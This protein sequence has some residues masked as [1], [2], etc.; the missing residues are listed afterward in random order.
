MAEMIIPGTYIDVRAEGLISAGRIASGIVGIIG[1]ASSGKIGTP[2]TLSGFAAAR[3]IFGL[4]DD[5]NN[6]EDGS[7]PLTL[8]RALQLLYNNGATNVIAVRVAKSTTAANAT[9]SVKDADGHRVAELSAVTAGSWGNDIKI[10]IENA[11]EPG[12]ISKETHTS[13]F[14][15]L[16]HHRILV[17]PSN[18]IQVVRGDTKRID[19]FDIVYKIIS[20][21]EEVTPN[22]EGRFFLANS[23]VAAVASVN[24][25]KVVGATGDEIRTYGDGHILYGAGAAP[26]AGEIR[27]DTATGE[28]IFEASQKPSTGQKLIATYAVDHE[29]PVS[30]QIL[31]TVW[32]GD[33]EFASGEAPQVVNGDVLNASYLIDQRNCV[34]VLLSCG[35]VNEKFTVPDGNMLVSMISQSSRLVT[36]VA[37]ATYRGNIPKAD[38]NGYFGTGSNIRGSNGADADEND[39]AAGLETLSNMLVNIVV[40]AGQDATAM[41]STILSH[42][43]TTEQTDQERIGVI[44]ASGDTVSEFL[45]HNLAN[46]RCIIAAPGI[47]LSDGTKLPPSY[48]AAAV[49]GLISSLPVQTSLTNRPLNVPSLSLYANRAEQEQLIKRN[50]LAIARKEGFRVVKGITTEGEGQPFSA[51]PTRRIV[52][53]AKYGVRSAANPYIGRLNNARVRAALKATLDAFLTRM[54]EDEALTGYELEVSATRAQEISGEVSVAMTIQPTFSIDFIRVVMTLK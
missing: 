52:D 28:V 51:I 3:E 48:T 18:R 43:Q 41:G 54:V 7:N 27:I 23:T 47:T 34:S 32:N 2:I 50:V 15:S 13:G 26:S 5:F 24:T 49:A 9:F 45:G 20:E 1:T 38:V 29:D 6:P 39:Y 31:V 30:G 36:A 14:A 16:N 44:G 21:K 4:P 40:L 46:G 11:G 10:T 42:L 12:R 25:F 37:D 33:I 22:T 8:V 17:N 35:Q 19:D 53:Y